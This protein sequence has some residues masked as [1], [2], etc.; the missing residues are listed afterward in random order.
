MVAI[1]GTVYDARQGD[2]GY[3]KVTTAAT[4]DDGDTITVDLT[5]YGA[6][7]IDWILG[8]IHSTT[9]S[10]LVQEQPTTSVSSGILTITVGGSTDDKKRTYLIGLAN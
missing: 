4:A 1:T 7:G 3:I 10:V 8:W 9:D 6:T 2:S 5:D